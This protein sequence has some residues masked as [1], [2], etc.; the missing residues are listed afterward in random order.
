[1]LYISHA[2]IIGLI[3]YFW[4]EHHGFIPYEYH[5]LVCIIAVVTVALLLH[6][7]IQRPVDVR[8]KSFDAA[9]RQPRGR[10]RRLYLTAG[11]CPSRRP[12]DIRR[13]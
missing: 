11:A 8:R 6:V 9:A 3:A 12:Q 7:L 4:N 10:G 5:W 1:M 2:P 13:T